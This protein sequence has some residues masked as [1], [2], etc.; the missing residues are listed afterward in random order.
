[1]HK[2]QKAKNQSYGTLKCMWQNELKMHGKEK[3]EDILE[4][5]VAFYNIISLWV[6]LNDRVL[7]PKKERRQ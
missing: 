2:I 3:K 7:P 4:S 5:Q 1:M 6:P